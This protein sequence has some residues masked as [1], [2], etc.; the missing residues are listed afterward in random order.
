[1]SANASDTNE[2]EEFERE[3]RRLE[4]GTAK[5]EGYYYVRADVRDMWT[6]W[7][8]RGELEAEQLED[9]QARVREL[10]EALQAS[11]TQ[12][13]EDIITIDGEWGSCRSLEELESDGE[14][15]SE[16]VQAR[17]MLST[18]TPDTALQKAL[19]EARIDEISNDVLRIQSGSRMLELREQLAALERNETLGGG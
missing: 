15:W 11:L 12:M 14:L 18:T 9:Y 5:D 13:E 7:Q 10:E 3:V 17:K 1:M 2:R 4:L 8:A 6:L 16:I 19:L